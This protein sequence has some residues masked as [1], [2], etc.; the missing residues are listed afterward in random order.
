MVN[1]EDIALRILTKSQS[2]FD[3][4]GSLSKDE[5]S[6]AAQYGSPARKAEYVR[7]RNLLKE[8]MLTTHSFHKIA[9]GVIGWPQGKV[10]S[11]SHKDGHIAV[12][13]GEEQ[14]FS[15]LGVD[16]ELTKKV[17][18]H[19]IEKVCTEN[20][21]AKYFPDPSNIHPRR[22]ATIFSLKESIYKA[23]YPLG[24][25]QFWFH[26]AEVCEWDEVNRLATLTLL[27]DTSPKTPKGST[28]DAKIFHQTLDGDDFVLTLAALPQTR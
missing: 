13:H 25:I 24:R 10:A 22:L 1:F 23:I 12:A 27:I 17:G 3:R 16:L 15:G 19:L 7:S 21:V 5:Q 14:K 2:G 28:I 6:E 11:L 9:S 4:L 8:E 26:D 20:E 18:A